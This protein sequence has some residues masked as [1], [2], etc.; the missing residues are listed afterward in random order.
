MARWSSGVRPNRKGKRNKVFPTVF[1]IME[2]VFAV[3]DA[4]ME[5]G[6]KGLAF[7]VE[8]CMSFGLYLLLIF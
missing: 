7:H 1:L 3:L 4:W 5:C 6:V 8:C 2:V